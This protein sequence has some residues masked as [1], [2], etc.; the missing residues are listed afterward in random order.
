MVRRRR[1]ERTSAPGR[2]KLRSSKGTYRMGPGLCNRFGPWFSPAGNAKKY[3]RSKSSSP[4]DRVIQ[5]LRH[6]A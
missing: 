4:H 3:G 1:P 6:S 2:R 5:A